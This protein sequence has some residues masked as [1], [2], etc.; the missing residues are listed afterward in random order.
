MAMQSHLVSAFRP[1]ESAPPAG[2]AGHLPTAWGGVGAALHDNWGG[3]NGPSW[4]RPSRPTESAPPAGFAGHL[5]TAWGGVGAALHG[6]WGGVNGPQLVSR[7]PADTIGPSGR[8]RRPPPH[9]V[10]RS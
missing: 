8:L 3:V 5:P 1:T 4:F 7:F 6:N 10:G 2:F 9:C